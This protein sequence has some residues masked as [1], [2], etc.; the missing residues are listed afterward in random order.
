MEC[1]EI[2]N[3]ISSVSDRSTIYCAAFNSFYSLQATQ[4]QHRGV[5][6]GSCPEPRL[7]QHPS[8]MAANGSSTASKTSNNAGGKPSGPTAEQVSHI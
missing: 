8:K 4:G 2:Q 6:P 7:R 1:E 5:L 3:C